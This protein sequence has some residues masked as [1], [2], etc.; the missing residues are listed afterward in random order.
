MHDIKSLFYMI[1]RDK[2][3]E[4]QIREYEKEFCNQ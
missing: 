3:Y 2:I 1:E 4:Q